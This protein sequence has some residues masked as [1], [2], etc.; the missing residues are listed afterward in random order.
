MNYFRLTV[1]VRWQAGTS[2]GKPFFFDCA[3]CDA[4]EI[5]VAGIAASLPLAEQRMVGIEHVG[6]ITSGPRGPR[7]AMFCVQCMDKIE[8]KEIA[9]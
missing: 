6:I 1:P 4:K 7:H 2:G 3:G 8:R 9:A 5:Q